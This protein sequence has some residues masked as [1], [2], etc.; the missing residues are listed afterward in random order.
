MWIWIGAAIIFT[1][2]TFIIWRE[3]SL[4]RKD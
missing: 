1:S 2:T 4:K 3:A